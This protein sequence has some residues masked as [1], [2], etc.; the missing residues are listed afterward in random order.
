MRLR[1]G[2]C[3]R[4]KGFCVVAF[5]GA[6]AVLPR[7][8]VPEHDRVWP[9][10]SLL[11]PSSASS[12]P[13]SYGRGRPGIM[14]GAPQAPQTPSMSKVGQQEHR[15]PPSPALCD[16]RSSGSPRAPQPVP[17]PPPCAQKMRPRVA[18]AS[19]CPPTPSPR[20]W[21]CPDQECPLDSP[22]QRLIPQPHSVLRRE[23][24]SDGTSDAS[25]TLDLGP[26]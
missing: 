15:P 26:G 4:V 2:V 16:A 11:V 1:A 8:M 3:A 9:W 21:L 23:G 6:D 17:W 25:R 18:Q 13:L 19:L 7:H 12:E 5:R 14:G 10:G 20:P 22:T 24:H